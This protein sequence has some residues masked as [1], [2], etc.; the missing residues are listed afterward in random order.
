MIL[1]AARDPRLVTVWRGGTLTDDDHRALARWS[2]TCA[3][4]VLPLFEDVEPLDLRPREA[5]EAVRAW[6]AASGG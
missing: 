6:A 3:E 2:A 5:V 4:H 1:P